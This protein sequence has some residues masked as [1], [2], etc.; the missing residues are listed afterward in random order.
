MGSMKLRL[1][2]A[3][4]ENGPVLIVA[5]T[6]GITVLGLL[7]WISW[8]ATGDADWLQWFF[9]YPS[10]MWAVGLT[11]IEF[12]F[13]LLAARRFTRGDALRTGWIWLTIA[14]A[15]HAGGRALALASSFTG[16]GSHAAVQLQDA[17]R[18]LGGPVQMIFLLIGLGGIARKCARAGLTERLRWTDHLALLLV[19]GVTLNTFYGIWRYIAD[20]KPVTWQVAIGWISDPAL[21]AL[22]FLA[23]FL[24][25]AAAAMGHGILANCWRSFCVA[26]VLT[27]LGD[28]SQ[29]CVQ[30]VIPWEWTTLGWFIWLMSDASYAL[31]PAFQVAALERVRI[32]SSLLDE[33]PRRLRQYGPL[34]E[35]LG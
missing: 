9:R 30:C 2:D 17:G 32:R 3:A 10:A 14:A 11:W 35:G 27:S 33:L 8:R 20:A 15:A 24:H 1:R 6:A 21:M 4:L 5:L 16:T 25:R 13:C 18:I 19:A 34:V 12:S 31:G 23:V 26:I 29:W 22:L 7:T 28:F